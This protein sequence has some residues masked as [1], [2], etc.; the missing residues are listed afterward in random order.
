MGF[1]RPGGTALA[2]PGCIGAPMCAVSLNPAQGPVGTS[3]VATASG[4]A[5][6]DTLSLYFD[7]IITPQT[8]ATADANGGARIPFNVPNL[9]GI[10]TGARTVTVQGTPSQITTSGVTFTITAAAALELNPA[11]G[12]VG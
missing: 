6:G 9:P 7:P 12:P 10:G 1:G 8:T 4:F 3:V 5:P 2:Q 11:Q